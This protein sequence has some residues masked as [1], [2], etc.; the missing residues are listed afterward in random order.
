MRTVVNFDTDLLP[1]LP[2]LHA[3]D[4]HKASSCEQEILDQA[5]EGVLSENSLNTRTVMMEAENT[6]WI[7]IK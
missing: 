2:V 1:D 3:A 6:R 4:K 5:D 7:V